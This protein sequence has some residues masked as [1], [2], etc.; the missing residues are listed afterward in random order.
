MHADVVKLIYV[1][2]NVFF[3]LKLQLKCLNKVIYER[4]LLILILI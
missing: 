3:V 2:I 4:V 1:Q